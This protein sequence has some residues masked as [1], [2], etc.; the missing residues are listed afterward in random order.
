MKKKQ[1]QGFLFIS[2]AILVIAIICFVVI[3]YLH[4]SNPENQFNFD[5][6]SPQ[7]EFTDLEPADQE[8][9][10]PDQS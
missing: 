10:S 6:V 2:L 8:T 1:R 5:L 3:K 4:D 9:I 7:G